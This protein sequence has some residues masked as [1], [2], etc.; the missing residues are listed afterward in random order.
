MCNGCIRIGPDESVGEAKRSLN[1]LRLFAG[2]KHGAQTAVAQATCTIC[3]AALDME[4]NR[5]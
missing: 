5:I 1:P 2:L 3:G 4:A